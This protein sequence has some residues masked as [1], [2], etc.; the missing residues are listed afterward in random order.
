MKDNWI[1]KEM[2]SHAADHQYFEDDRLVAK[3]KNIRAENKK[4]EGFGKSLFYTKKIEEHKEKSWGD[5]K[6]ESL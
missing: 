1:V 4:N 5:A 2:M 6:M 3:N